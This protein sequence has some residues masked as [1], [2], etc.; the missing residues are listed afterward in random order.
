M[1]ALRQ[2]FLCSGLKPCPF[3]TDNLKFGRIRASRRYPVK[4]FPFLALIVSTCLQAQGPQLWDCQNTNAVG[5]NW[6][7]EEGYR[8]DI[9]VVPKISIAL[10]INGADSFFIL[11]SEN[12]PLSCAET[13]ND[14]GENLISCIR[15]DTQPYDFIV[16]NLTSGQASLSRLEGSIS[17]NTFFRETVSTHIFQCLK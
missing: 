5:F 12:I 8:W 9:K 10:N 7:T 13:K 1:T 15:A 2:K 17:S 11:N 6:N 14:M 4:N 3:I 16:L